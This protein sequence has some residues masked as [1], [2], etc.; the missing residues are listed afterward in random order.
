MEEAATSSQMAHSLRSIK[1]GA[2]ARRCGAEKDQRAHQGRRLN[3]GRAAATFQY[4]ENLTIGN[5][6]IGNLLGIYF[7]EQTTKEKK[8][9]MG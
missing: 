7:A 9:R 3:A 4:Q 8:L 5:L 6:L 2:W 1:N